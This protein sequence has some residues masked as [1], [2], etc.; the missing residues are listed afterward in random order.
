MCERT[1]RKR[2]ET[3]AERI[4]PAQ[5]CY[6]AL[7]TTLGW[8]ISDA[9][10]RGWTQTIKDAGIRSRILATTIFC[11]SWRFRECVPNAR[12]TRW[13]AQIC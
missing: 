2:V 5:T 13:S 4:R 12:Y 10:R 1:A 8:G 7:A 9:K 6:G 11:N 3:I